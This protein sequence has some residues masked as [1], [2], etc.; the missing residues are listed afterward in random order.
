M[1]RQQQQQ[2]QERKGG[3]ED[4]AF[5]SHSLSGSTSAAL[6]R[7]YKSGLAATAKL[8]RD[9][10]KKPPLAVRSTQRMV[11]GGDGRATQAATGLLHG[12]TGTRSGDTGTGTGTPALGV[13]A[14]E[15]SGARGR[16][17]LRYRDSWRSGSSTGSKE[18]TVEGTTS[19]PSAAAAAADT[20]G[21]SHRHSGGGRE[22][23]PL[24]GATS[25]APH[26]VTLEGATERRGSAATAA[27][28]AA[29]PERS[30]M[31]SYSPFRTPDRANAS[32]AGSL[33]RS[34]GEMDKSVQVDTALEVNE[35]AKRI[36]ASID[37][38]NEMM[39]LYS[40]PQPPAGQ[41]QSP[42]VKELGT[43]LP[44]APAASSSAVAPSS[45]V[46]S[47]SA[48]ASA[49]THE[50]AVNSSSMPSS[51]MLSSFSDTSS[52]SSSLDPVLQRE[53][54][55]LE[56]LV[57]ALEDRKQRF[58]PSM[59]LLAQ[60]QALLDERRRR[61]RS[62]GLRS[63]S[64]SP[65]SSAASSSPT[66]PVKPLPDV[67]SLRQVIDQGRHQTS[68]RERGK[69]SESSGLSSHKGD[70]P[71][72]SPSPRISS[73]L[74][75]GVV[76]SS[77]GS[78]SDG[79]SG[80][81]GHMSESHLMSTTFGTTFAPGSLSAHSLASSLRS[82]E[83]FLEELREAGELEESARGRV[84]EE[85]NASGGNWTEERPS[86]MSPGDWGGAPWWEEPVSLSRM[87]EG[88]TES[89][90]SLSLH[91]LPPDEELEDAGP[92][93]DLTVHSLRA[94]S[95]L[96]GASVESLPAL[97]THSLTSAAAASAPAPASPA[98]PADVAE[99]SQ[100]NLSV[101]SLSLSLLEAE[102]EEEELS[103]G[104]LSDVGESQLDEGETASQALQEMERQEVMDAVIAGGIY[105]SGGLMPDRD[106]NSRVGS[107]S[108]P[109][110]SML[111]VT[112]A[113]VAEL[114]QSSG[115]SS[116]LEMSSGSLNSSGRPG[117]GPDSTVSSSEAEAQ[118]AEARRQSSAQSE[119]I[120]EEEGVKVDQSKRTGWS[121]TIDL[122][123]DDSL[124]LS[125]R[126][127]DSVSGGQVPALPQVHT[128]P[129]GHL[130]SNL[131]AGMAIEW[132]LK[133]EVSSSGSDKGKIDVLE[134]GETES[135]PSLSEQFQSRAA[136]FIEKSRQRTLKVAQLR[137]ARISSR[138]VQPPA[139]AP[140]QGGK[141]GRAAPTSTSAPLGLGRPKASIGAARAVRQ[142]VSMEEARRRTSSTF[143][144]L[145]EVRAERKKKMEAAARLE[146]LKQSR[147]AGSRR[148]KG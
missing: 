4:G 148:A 30:R 50:S 27:A 52:R 62:L 7:D 135:G 104:P 34:P 74:S 110:P 21:R 25:G 93:I 68:T 86:V 16:S 112:D 33:F 82:H 140:R 1:L 32:Y 92:P 58:D 17:A 119:R 126:S 70:S 123:E 9:I 87:A 122:S 57:Q 142:P 29:T 56:A 37:D 10:G 83:A 11:P 77:A 103:R 98:P 36:Q 117:H 78:S 89:A 66:R 51:S 2:E 115:G 23:V 41:R 54:E 90:E 35:W 121:R 40:E 139:P 49:S 96:A 84:E 12:G 107:S 136:A 101:D 116:E 99:L 53:A 144:N 18:F 109:E 95:S 71:S 145:P 15:A 73:T 106:A 55:T 43:T 100:Q 44:T 20:R 114:A 88:R 137:E 38:M 131:E 28:A 24:T 6:D 128:G 64:R 75:P 120:A 102:G 111:E 26:R 127:Q 105:I 129:A 5:L 94:A 45:A 60:Q 65:P 85:V 42:S 138:Q 63:R 19:G 3:R 141:P 113:M 80:S 39:R 48:S 143:N 134:K 124:G 14:V 81:Q 118:L 72:H 97:S 132:H 59:D 13:G 8:S 130:V 91:S 108:S 47:T 76:T 22:Q 133:G 31:H 79:A 69:G 147:E 125:D 61:N 67:Q 46:A 146:R